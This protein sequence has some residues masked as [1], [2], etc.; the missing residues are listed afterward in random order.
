MD[1]QTQW[2]V[3]MGGATG[4]DYAGVRAHLNE[5]RDAGDLPAEERADVWRC[6]RSAERA[7]LDV[8]SERRKAADSKPP[9]PPAG[10]VIPGLM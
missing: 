5:L 2:R 10:P 7:T 3:G 1:V 4:L 9:P 8:W 6:I